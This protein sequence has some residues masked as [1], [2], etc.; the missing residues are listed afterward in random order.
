MR[1]AN[2]KV[3]PYAVL[4][5][6]GKELTTPVLKKTRF[7]RWN[8]TYE[9]PIRQPLDDPDNRTVKITIF[10]NDKF[11]HDHFLGE[12]GVVVG[13]GLTRSYRW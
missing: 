5:Y 7:P 3:D 1:D 9:I 4:N 10:D 11:G 12:V 8:K 6:G 2:S 13:R